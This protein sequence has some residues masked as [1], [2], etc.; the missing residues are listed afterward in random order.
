[1]ATNPYPRSR[2]RPQRGSRRG[3]PARVQRGRAARPGLGGVPAEPEFVSEFEFA[4]KTRSS[5][6]DVDAVAHRLHEQAAQ[7]ANR[8]ADAVQALRR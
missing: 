3:T 4:Q 7:R 8:R 5:V 1:M 6:G 2:I